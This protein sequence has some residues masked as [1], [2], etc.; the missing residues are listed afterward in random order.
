MSIDVNLHDGSGTNRSA[1]VDARSNGPNGIVSYT[2]PYHERIGQT[3][4]LINGTY[5]ADFN[6]NAAY[7][8]TPDGIHDGTDAVEW[9]GTN[10][11]G[12]NFIFNSTAQAN[13]GTKSID[14]TATVDA[15]EAIFTRGSAIDLSGYTAITGAIYITGWANDQKNI[16][17]QLQLA[18]VLIGNAISINNYID[19]G[20][21]NTWQTFAIP[22]SDF[23]ATTGNAD[24]LVVRTI[25]GGGGQPPNYYLD[26]L[27]LEETG[28]ATFIVEPDLGSILEISTMQITIAD[29]YVS[30]LA[31]AT[32][33]KIPYNTLLGVSAL[34][35]GIRFT[36][37][38][39]SVVRFNSTFK[40]HI[41]FMTF[42]GL[43]AQS[44]GDGTNTWLTYTINFEPAFVLNSKTKDKLEMSITED[45]SGLLFGRCLV[46]GGT[47]TPA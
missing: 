40:Q 22:L 10:Q 24:E 44:G 20:T 7:S 32:H 47:Y 26:D 4:A 19:T 14:A 5:G 41:D 31:D 43:T 45:L 9:T 39:D 37:T 34:S 18:G 35:D 11:V 16:E 6:A 2:E 17:L 3:K 38:T 15:D 12:T 28:G 29:A 25:S 33:Q 21:L 27:Q 23:T 13:S 1:A 30:T 8:G 36:L 46:R 42:P